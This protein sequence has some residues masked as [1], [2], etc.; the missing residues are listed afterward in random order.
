VN[1]YEAGAFFGDLALMY[2]AP[3][4]ATITCKSAGSLWALDR[5]AFRL[6]VVRRNHTEMGEHSKFLSSIEMLSVLTDEQREAIGTILEEAT[7]KQGEYLMKQGDPAEEVF[8]LKEGEVSA[9]RSRTGQGLGEEVARMNA[10]AVIGESALKGEKEKRAASIRAEAKVVTMRLGREDFMDMVGDLSELAKTNFNNRIINSIEMFQLLEKEE[11]TMLLDSLVEKE[12]KRGEMIIQ[13]ADPGDSMYIIMEGTVTVTQE[14]EDGKIVTIQDEL[15]PGSYFGEMALINNAPR[16]ATVS[17]T[18]ALMTMMLDRK[19]FTQVLG[20]I[21]DIL[22]RET[23]RREKEIERSKR[24]PIR[25]EDLTIENIL[26]VGTFGRVKLAVHKKTFRPYALK[27][28][29]KGQII[30]LKQVEHVINEKRVMTLLD[31]PFILALESFYQDHNEIYMLLELALGGE[32]FSALRDQGKFDEDAA[33]FYGACVASGFA[34]MHDRKIIYRDLKPENL[35]FDPDGYIKM[36]DFGF[37]KIVTNRTFTLCGTNEYLAP[38]IIQ[39]KGHSHPVDWWAFGILIFEMMTGQ[40]PFVAEDPMEIYKKIINA[41]HRLP[42]FFP[43]KCR[44]IIGDLLTK[45]PIKRLGSF[46]G[47]A[48]DIKQ[49][50]WFD[51]I[52]YGDLEDKAIP[53]PYLPIIDNPTD[54]SNFDSYEEEP[55]EVWAHYLTE[56]TDRFFDAYG[57][58]LKQETVHSRGSHR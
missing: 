55:G 13:Q 5:R 48:I 6:I 34:F 47:G 43:K 4:A 45:N 16:M 30:G 10:G 24:E 42:W 36:I 2:D 27:C 7:F 53:P 1:H 54:T 46:R 21:K 39:H 23:Q 3:R 50:D 41:K 51:E 52:D 15:G 28:M 31:H 18:S 38:E 25:Y 26:G 9:W 44:N 8:F 22:E 14:T 37:A 32:L 40:P 17:A 29:R 49:H 35:L 20:P 19:T 58:R 33:R 57:A 11:Q 56:K 12:F